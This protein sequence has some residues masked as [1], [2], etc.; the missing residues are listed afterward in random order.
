MARVAVLVL[1]GL[2]L[3]AAIVAAVAILS[4]PAEGDIRACPAGSNDLNG[5]CWTGS[6]NQTLVGFDRWTS[7][8]TTGRRNTDLAAAGIVVVALLGTAGVLQLRR[9]SPQAKEN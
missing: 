9:R 6:T 7:G 4:L 8:E 1:L 3:A 5:G 2:A